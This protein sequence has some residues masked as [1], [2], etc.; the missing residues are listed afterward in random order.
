[1]RASGEANYPHRY[2]LCFSGLT[3]FDV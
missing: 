2:E 3:I 1:V